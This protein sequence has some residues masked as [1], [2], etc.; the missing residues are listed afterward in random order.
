M[1][2]RVGNGKFK[3][4]DVLLTTI[5]VFLAMTAIL[6]IFSSSSSDNQLKSATSPSAKKDAIVV[7]KSDSNY[8]GVQI[9]TETS[10]DPLAKYAIQYPQSKNKE[11]NEQVTSYITQAKKT[12]L[13]AMRNVKNEDNKKKSE[14]NISYETY[15]D[16][17]GNYSF[18][19]MNNE[20]LQGVRDS[21]KSNHST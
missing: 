13:E 6:L 12:Y 20:S 18:V 17:K 3:L 15:E 8:E 7:D 5:I 21:L 1:N 11:F 19:L 16:Q 2:K 9:V 14:L 4:I 10:N